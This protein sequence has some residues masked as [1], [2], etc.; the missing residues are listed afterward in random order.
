MYNKH[1]ENREKNIQTQNLKVI[2]CHMFAPEPVQTAIGGW[3]GP[4]EHLGSTLTK[5]IWFLL[6]A[7]LTETKIR[8]FWTVKKTKYQP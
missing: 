7:A 2:F 5:M 6:G 8:M 4:V 1:T 3:T